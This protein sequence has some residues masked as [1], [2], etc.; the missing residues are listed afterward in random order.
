MGKHWLLSHRQPI[1]PSKDTSIYQK[2]WRHYDMKYVVLILLITWTSHVSNVPISEKMTR[3]IPGV[4][5]PTRYKG[6]YQKLVATSRRDIMM[7]A[8]PV[9]ILLI[10]LTSCQVPDVVTDDDA[11]EFDRGHCQATHY[12]ST[13]EAV[14]DTPPLTSDWSIT[15][16]LDTF[17]IPAIGDPSWYAEYD[18][19]RFTPYHFGVIQAMKDWR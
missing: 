1:E 13:F 10:A 5:L 7:K 17:E 19:S 2:K 3:D 6:H 16:F 4:F 9:F 15:H 12:F 14:Y 18:Y 8:F 11:M